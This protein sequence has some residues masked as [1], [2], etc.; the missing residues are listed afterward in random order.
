MATKKEENS[1]EI[2]CRDIY[3]KHVRESQEIVIKHLKFL[4]HGQDKV[5][6]RLDPQKYGIKFIDPKDLQDPD[7]GFKFAK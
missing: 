6:M 2:V 1:F 5:L 3:C 4:F 7:G